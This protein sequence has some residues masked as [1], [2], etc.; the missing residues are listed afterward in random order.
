MVHDGFAFMHS[1][2]VKILSAALFA[3]PVLYSVQMR[4]SSSVNASEVG[5]QKKEA[6]KIEF[7]I[8]LVL[9]AVEQ[10][11]PAWKSAFLAVPS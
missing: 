7:C 10:D 3:K 6:S 1:L 5:K 2:Q 8:R 9:Q 11:I 4:L